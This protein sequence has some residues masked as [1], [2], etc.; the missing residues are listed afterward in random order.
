MRA[1][2]LLHPLVIPMDLLDVVARLMILG[3][4]PCSAARR[5]SL[6]VPEV[7]GYVRSLHFADACCC[8]Q[9]TH[10]R[11][12]LGSKVAVALVVVIRQVHMHPYNHEVR[13]ELVADCRSLA[14]IAAVGIFVMLGVGEW[15]DIEGLCFDA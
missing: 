3:G 15:L 13:Y 14:D 1:V 7:P 5:P 12:S 2:S 9:P 11:S 8:S 4:L 6:A 10:L